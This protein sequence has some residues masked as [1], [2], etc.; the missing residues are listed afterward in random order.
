[1]IEL[2]IMKELK[3]MNQPNQKNVMF[4]AIGIYY[5][6]GVSFKQMYPI[7]AMIY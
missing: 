3:L 7:D 5:I 4:V 6:K 1:M 2:T